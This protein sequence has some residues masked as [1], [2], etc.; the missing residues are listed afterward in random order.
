MIAFGA[1]RWLLHHRSTMARVSR[2]KVRRSGAFS[3]RDIVGCEARSSPLSGSRGVVAWIAAGDAP[4]HPSSSSGDA[5]GNRASQL[6]HAIQD[7]DG[8]TNFCASAFV[9]VEAQPIADYLLISTDR[10]LDTTSLRMA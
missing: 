1:R 2:N 4:P 8:D 6:R 3:Q 10:G 7:V 9:L 5:D